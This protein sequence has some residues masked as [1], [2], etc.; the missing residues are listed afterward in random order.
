M[1]CIYT[2][3][4]TL[5]HTQYIVTAALPLIMTLRFRDSLKLHIVLQCVITE[6][7]IFN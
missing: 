5:L 3:T 2:H 1:Q 6:V 7:F 4:H